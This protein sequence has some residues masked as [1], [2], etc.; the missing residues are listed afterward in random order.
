MK[1]LML[2]LITVILA[3]FL[4]C[5]KSSD[6]PTSPSSSNPTAG[7]WKLSTKNGAAPV[8][9]TFTLVINSNGTW[10][11][12]AVITSGPTCTG[13]GTS[14]TSGNNLTIVTTTES[15]SSGGTYPLTETGTYIV[16]A[17]TLT[18]TM[19]GDVSVYTKK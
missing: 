17:T 7:T 8:G 6:S 13:N 3:M 9:Y 10:T 16:T 1:K 14:S 4:G 12:T 18:T 19:P 15:C 2:V 11:Y 5:N